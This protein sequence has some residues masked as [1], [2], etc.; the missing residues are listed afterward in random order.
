MIAVCRYL[1]QIFVLCVV[2]WYLYSRNRWSRAPLTYLVWLKGA[3][4]CAYAKK[5]PQ[6]YNRTWGL[7]TPNRQEWLWNCGLVAS[8]IKRNETK[9]GYIQHCWSDLSYFIPNVSSKYVWFVLCYKNMPNTHSAHTVLQILVS[10]P[11]PQL[12]LLNASLNYISWLYLPSLVRCTLINHKKLH[13][14]TQ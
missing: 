3:H 8:K 7:R 9:F 14:R 11:L 4:L 6:K 1:W 5:T 2:W 13:R 12:L 10:T